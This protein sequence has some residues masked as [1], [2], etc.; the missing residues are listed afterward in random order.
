[1]VENEYLRIENTSSIPRNGFW[2]F[3]ELKVCPKIAQCGNSTFL[4]DEKIT[5]RIKNVLR[6]RF[7]L[8][9]FLQNSR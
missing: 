6:D 9:E 8:W 3:S 5:R 1:M 4:N 7:N 2:I